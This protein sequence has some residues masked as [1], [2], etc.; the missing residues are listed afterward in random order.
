M[1]LSGLRGMIYGLF[2]ALVLSTLWVTSLTILSSPANAENVLTEAGAQVL[3]PFMVA[4]GLGLS[5]HTYA[6][7]EVS[8]K[9]HPNAPLALSVIKVR[10]LG[11]EIAGKPYADGVRVVY[12]HVAE[13]YYTGG[14]D[15]A[16]NIPPQLKS[17]LPNFALFNPDNIPIIQGGPTPTQLPPFLRPFF[18]FVGLTP[19]TFTAGGHQ[20]IADLLPWFWIVTIVLGVLAVVLNRSERKFEGLLQ[21]I[22][23]GTWP[24]VGILLALWVGALLFHDRFAPYTGLLGDISAAFLPVYGVAFALGLGG[25]IATRVLERRQKSSGGGASAPAAVTP[26]GRAPAFAADAPTIPG[27]PPA[28]GESAE[29]AGDP[30]TSPA[31]GA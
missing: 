9:A 5:E 17:A 24:V 28:A 3:N 2:G 15:A 29:M 12:R 26:T 7:L 22:I 14:A 16:F 10:V 4:H 6:Q 13:A 19:A 25:L 31:P 11:H 1:S 27:A 8:A 21:G 30:P 18:T 20:R 23:H